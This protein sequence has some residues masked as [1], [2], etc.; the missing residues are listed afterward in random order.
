[1]TIKDI[2]QLFGYFTAQ[3]PILRTFSWGNLADY[4]RDEYITKYP[5]FHAVP[6]PSLV[7]KNF[8]DFNFNILIYDLLNEYVDGDPVN[9]NQLDSLALTETI[10]NDFY[11]FFT[12][13]LTQYGYFLTTSVNYTPFMDRFK[14]DVVGIEATITIRVEQTA[15]IPDFILENG[16]L[17]YENGNTMTSQDCEVVSYASPACPSG[18]RPFLCSCQTACA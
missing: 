4:S 10:L 13:Q 2:I 8:A 7:D 9:S 18:L 15:C 17:L 11:A 5:A 16:F 1:M 3:H 6:Q 12:N 14:E